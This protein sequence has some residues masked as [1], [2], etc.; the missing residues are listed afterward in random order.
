M[1]ARLSELRSVLQGLIP[2]LILSQIC[3][4]VYVHMSL[5]CNG[6]WFWNS[7]SAAAHF[8]HSGVNNIR[9]SHLWDRDNPHETVK[10]N[11]Q[12]LF[13]INVWCGVIGDQLI[14]LYILPQ[15]RTGDIYANYLQTN[16]QHSYRTFL[17]KYEV[18]CANSMTECHLISVRLSGSIWI[19]DSQTDG[20]VV[21][22]HSIG[23]QGHRI[24][25]H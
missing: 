5:I 14:G 9:N 7:W 11:Y 3:N 20:L 10:S 13:A 8:T 4:T 24:W 23:H 15:C 6:C 17:Y 22:V 18:R 12:H 1:F 16:C 25:T 2:E 21:A 19:I